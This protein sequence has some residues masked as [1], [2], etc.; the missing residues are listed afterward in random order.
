LNDPAAWAASLD[1]L[2]NAE[3]VLL[4][5]LARGRPPARVCDLMQARVSAPTQSVSSSYL[6]RLTEICA[7]ANL[8]PAPRISASTAFRPVAIVG[9]LSTTPLPATAPVA[10]AY[11]ELA[12]WARSGAYIHKT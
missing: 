7:R 11:P 3:N 9:H 5:G 8:P 6:Y 2:P 1:E 12:A 4:M 10:P